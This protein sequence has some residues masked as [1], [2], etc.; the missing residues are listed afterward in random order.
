M[1]TDIK[2]PEETSEKLDKASEILGLNK[3]KLI[4]RALLLYLDNLEKY[5]DL[6]KEFNL[7]DELSDEALL[8]FEKPL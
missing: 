5:L 6:K 4:D 7:W 3:E 8:D 2:I 1:T